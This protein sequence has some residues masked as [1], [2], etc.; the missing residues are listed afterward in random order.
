MKESRDGSTSPGSALP[1]P[2]GSGSR[3]SRSP[4]KDEFNC[5]LNYAYGVLYSLVERGCLLSGLDPC[6]GLMHTDNY[7]KPSL[8]YDLIELF[9]VHAER[10]VVNLFAA[11]GQAGTVRPGRRGIPA[12]RRGRAAPGALNDHLDQSKQHGRRRLKVR[13]TIVYE[14]QR[15]A[16]RLIRGLDTEHEVDMSVFD[17]AAQLDLPEAASA[18]EGT[19]CADD[20]VPAVPDEATRRAS[21]RP[22]WLQLFGV[23]FSGVFTLNLGTVVTTI[24]PSATY[25]A[26]FSSST[27]SSLVTTT[28]SPT[29]TSATTSPTP[30]P[31]PTHGIAIGVGVRVGAWS[32]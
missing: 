15:L 14:C 30:S 19:A 7:N 32:A 16:G 8:V 28:S 17:L 26:S 23:R 24:D 13:D 2:N 25:T 4:A 11:E 6:I 20:V 5:L 3:R 9:R 31:A 29:G 18:D 10:V 12:Q 21:A 27:S 1:C 22:Q